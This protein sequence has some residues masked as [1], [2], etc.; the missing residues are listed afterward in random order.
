MLRAKGGLSVFLV[1]LMSCLLVAQP[2]SVYAAD[3]SKEK[4]LIDQLGK[5]I[6]RLRDDLN[7]QKS[8]EAAA[9]RDLAADLKNIATVQ[10]AITAEAPRVQQ[11]LNDRG[12]T[13]ALKTL[14][15][16]VV[17]AIGIAAAGPEAWGLFGHTIAALAELAD[18]AH[19]AIEVTK[20]LKEGAEA[21]AVMDEINSG[22]GN[23][24]A[25]RAYAEENNLTEFTKLLDMEDQLKALMTKFDQD[26]KRLKFAHNAVL[27]DE[28]LLAK[29][30]KQLADAFEAYWACLDKPGP[31]PSACEEGQATNPDG[32]GVCR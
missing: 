8:D 1:I 14:A 29:L 7:K 3:C 18:Q 2:I 24:E 13:E 31:V 28:A 19:T 20:L 5:D 10:Q 32:A 4:A 11:E 25:A 17:I 9:Q 21:G 15:V 12:M 23:T 16:Q 22:M 27:G 6:S 30:A 26:W